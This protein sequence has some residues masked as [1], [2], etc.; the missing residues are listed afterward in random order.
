MMSV[1]RCKSA[2]HKFIHSREKSAS[3]ILDL[4]I[5]HLKQKGIKNIILDFD[6]V[7]SAHNKE[8]PDKKVKLWLHN[9]I[10][11]FGHK[12]IF[13]LSNNKNS[14]RLKYFNKHFPKL[15][16]SE[17][18]YYKPYPY[19]IYKLI[20]KFNIKNLTNIILIDDRLLTGILL[21]LTV[22]INSLYIF[23]PVSD[24]KKNSIKEFYISFLRKLDLLIFKLVIF[25]T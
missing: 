23:K 9:A 15:V 17:N 5:K 19:D 1:Y 16:F 7:I 25:F 21:S 22:G 8:K 24:L 3:S 6:G 14:N 11:T 12:H 20:K 4:D 13:V 18:K 2:L 10:K